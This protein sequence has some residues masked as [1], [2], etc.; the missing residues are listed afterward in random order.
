MKLI[1]KTNIYSEPHVNSDNPRSSKT[2]SYAVG[3]FIIAVF[4]SSNSATYQMY[5]AGVWVSI[6]V[7]DVTPPELPGAVFAPATAAA[8]GRSVPSAAAQTPS[9]APEEDEGP[10]RLLPPAS[11]RQEQCDQQPGGSPR[12]AA[13]PVTRIWRWD[14][15][16]IN[17]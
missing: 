17:K 12:S 6:A 5:F 14:L 10:A 15:L 11:P 13:E 8:A 1:W 9:A 4:S 3:H 2:I 16:T 7:C